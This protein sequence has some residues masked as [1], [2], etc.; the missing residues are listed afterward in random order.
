MNPFKF[1]SIVDDPFFTNRLKEQEQIAKLLNSNNHLILISPRRYGKTSL[2]L[3][4][5]K[6]QERPYIFLD[7]Q[8]ITDTFD[9]AAQ[10]LKRVNRAYPY[11]RFKDF[12]RNFRVLPTI[13]L[14]PMTNEVDLG[15]QSVSAAQPLLDDVLN[16]IEKL[17]E[18][19]KRPIVV[20]DEFQDIHRI[21]KGLDRKMRSVLQHHAHVNYAFLG[22]MESMM[23]EIFERKQSPFYHFGMMMTLD[24]IPYQEF[25][26][27]LVK[28]FGMESTEA[29][30]ISEQILEFTHCHPYY[31]QQL[32]FVL[33]DQ[34]STGMKPADRITQ[35]IQSIITTHDADYERL[36]Q[37]QNQTD[38]KVL[39]SLAQNEGN[40]LSDQVRLRNGLPA[41]STVY[42]SLKRLL[43]QGYVLKN[44]EGY[45]IDDPYFAKWILKRRN[46]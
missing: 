46:Q 27:Y 8:L 12:L 24:K 36:W 18:N 26:D 33:F 21:E 6:Q 20:L 2:I 29:E 16:L 45:S 38:R 17:G 43:A 44:Q 39:V 37:L 3:K 35:A 42:S 23:R 11:E 10:L 34:I 5:L 7:L 30:D 14:N 32:A 19:G 1:G 28:G 22:S 4:V 15:F 9:L 41:M 31:T 25:K 13:S 40:V